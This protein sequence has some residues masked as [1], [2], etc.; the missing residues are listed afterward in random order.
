[1]PNLTVQ[2]KV[3]IPGTNP[4]TVLISD[5]ELVTNAPPP[6]TLVHEPAPWKGAMVVGLVAF[7]VAKLLHTD[8]FAPGIETTSL[9]V[10]VI[11]AIDGH[12]PFVTVHVKI[13]TPGANPVTFV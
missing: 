1:V 2:R 10:I 5:N 6:P 11:L 7:S 13:F 3:L 12:V 4:V 8:W 9:L